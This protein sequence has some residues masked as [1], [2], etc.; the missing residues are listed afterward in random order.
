MYSSLSTKRVPSFLGE[1]KLIQNI[2]INL[3]CRNSIQNTS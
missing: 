1:I 2:Q 3:M